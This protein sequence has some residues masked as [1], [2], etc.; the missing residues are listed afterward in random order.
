MIVALVTY[1]WLK[2]GS[3]SGKNPS[4]TPQSRSE[5]ADPTLRRV[6]LFWGQN[7]T[8]SGIKR[9]KFCPIQLLK[10]KLPNPP[11]SF[12]PLPTG[13]LNHVSFY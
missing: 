9:S 1:K 11:G 6:V 8:A 3:C 2:E 12:T 10:N 13:R 4:T 7:L 5:F